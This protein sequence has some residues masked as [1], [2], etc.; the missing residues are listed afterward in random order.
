MGGHSTTITLSVEGMDCAS[1]AAHIEEAVRK[2]PGVDDVHVLVAAERATIAY[3]PTVATREHL[4]GAIHTAGYHV[5]DDTHGETVAQHASPARTVSGI[6]G[7]GVLG[8]V[9]L[10]VL[11]ASLGEQLGFADALAE[12]LP[13]WIPA[14]AVAIG[15]YSVFKGVLQAALRS[16][17]TSHTLMSTGVLAAAAIGEWTTAALLVFFMRFADFLENLTT[18]RSR[19]ALQQLAALQ[20]ATA[21][22][23]RDGR[24]V[25]VPIAEVGVGERVVV[26]PGQR[27]P[28]DG[29]VID[30]QA[31]VDQ[32]PITGESIAVDKRSGDTVFAATIAQGGFLAIETT[33]AS[34]DTTFARIVRLVEEA[35]AQKAPV[36]RFADKFSTYY[37]PVVLITAL[38]TFLV[39]GQILNTVAVLVV[40]CSCA[41]ALAT[42]VVVLASVGTAAQR[43]LLIKG[44]LALEQLARVD[45]L[46]VDKTGTLTK[47]EPEVTDIVP[48]EGHADELLRVVA[49][50]ERRSEHPLARAMVRAAAERGIG[51]GTVEQF[52]ARSGMG[53]V[54][55]V[56]GQPWAIGNRRLLTQR[57]VML[58]PAHEA[59]A[60]ALEHA[61]KTVF[62]VATTTRVAGLI[63]LADVLRPEVKA[64][65]SRLQRLGV[66]RTV[67][68]TGDNERVAA[69]IAAELGL[70]YRANLL[71][72]DKIAAVKVLQQAGA[73][74]LMVGD[75]VNDAPAL[76]QADVG[77]AMGVAGTDVA[78]EAADVALMR[79]DWQMVP[80]A[81]QLSRRARRT[82]RQNLGFTAVYNIVG[83]TLAAVGILPPVWAAAAQSLP[84]V[85][86]MLNSARLLRPSRTQRDR[87]G[88]RSTLQRVRGYVS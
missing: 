23:L 86:I 56:E 31:S 48:F 76:A 66:T 53:L 27:I 40:A 4:V 42:P 60:Q 72:E 47:G 22:V 77:A 24:E 87:D 55:V 36:Q 7:R 59:Q 61:G 69:R 19:Q 82:I 73:V 50:L 70:E 1:C 44:G 74:V 71:P 88:A 37:L 54:G 3:D 8:M 49:S 6:I 32:A 25:E 15:G 11:V 78:I 52:T 68:L 33:K 38:T 30:G 35:E 16:Q 85:A 13:W 29:R 12:W 9:A 83:L 14:L 18:E 58:E 84:D 62:F 45:T 67:L 39:T 81:I 26:R 10:I 65:L 2:V 28:V 20:P 64:A 79:D 21:H 41:I 17:I 51:H 57:Q 43:G 46:V 5:P 75:G 63:A 80:E 34:S